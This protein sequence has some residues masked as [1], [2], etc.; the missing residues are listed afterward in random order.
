MPTGE[1]TA[2]RARGRAGRAHRRPAAAAGRVRQLQ[3]PRRP[4][5]RARQA[6][7]DVARCSTALLR[8]STTSTGPAS[9]A[10]STGGFKAVAESL[11]RTVAGLGLDDVRRARRRVRPAVHEALMPHRE[12]ARRHRDDLQ[13]R[14]PGR[15]PDRRA[16]RPPGAGRWS[17]TPPSR[18]RP[19][20]REHDADR[21]D[22]TQSRG[23]CAHEHARRGSGRLGEEG[24]LPGP[25]RR[26][27]RVGRRHQEGLP[28]AGARQ[29][30]RLQPGRPAAEERFKEISEAY[31][32]LSDAEKRKEY[33]ELRALL[34]RLRRRL[35]RAGRG[36]GRRLRPRRP[37]RRPGRRRRRRRLRR[38][39]RRHVRRRRRAP[40]RTP[41]RAGADVETDGRR[42]ASTRRSRASRSRCG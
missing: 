11:E 12:V 24:L 34:R 26:Q 25:R 15:L 7:R 10:S 42:S 40:G 35:P 4:R 19:T 33:D 28:Q 29:P 23:R 8:C 21:H 36:G 30:P 3:A 2:R 38:P 9:T 14:S 6:E 16:R 31:D 22:E 41:R 37:V 13:G 39:V 17:S 32:V 18:R 27:G 1:P 20:G 5:P